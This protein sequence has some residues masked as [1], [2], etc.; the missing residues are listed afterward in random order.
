MFLSNVNALF[1]LAGVPE[2]LILTEANWVSAF[3][4]YA[5]LKDNKK[6]AISQ[7][8]K[9]IKFSTEFHKELDSKMGSLVDETC[10]N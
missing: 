7:I 4:R 8:E 5:T 2:S 1:A 3:E 10:S 6:V 9:Y